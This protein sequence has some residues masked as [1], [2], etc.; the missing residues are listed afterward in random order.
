MGLFGFS[1]GK[2]MDEYVAEAAERGITIVDMREQNEFARGRVPG[3]MN[4]PLSTLRQATQAIADKEAPL[5]VHCLSGARS[6]RA[7][8]QLAQMG[9]TNVT[10]IGGINTYRGPIEK[11]F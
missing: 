5:Y 3:A 6:S 1:I 2:G 9:F 11:G 7:A 10:N 4:I 8:K